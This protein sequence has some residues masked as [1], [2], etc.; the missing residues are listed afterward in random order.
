MKYSSLYAGTLRLDV[1]KEKLKPRPESLKSICVFPKVC[2]TKMGQYY[3]A[4]C[5]LGC[6]F[7]INWCKMKYFDGPLKTRHDLSSFDNFTVYYKKKNTHQDMKGY[8][9]EMIWDKNSSQI[10]IYIIIPSY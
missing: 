1:A 6:C 2:I 9:V 8:R 4:V 7:Y 10:P 3:K 5:H